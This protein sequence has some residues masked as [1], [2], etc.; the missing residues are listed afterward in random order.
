MKHGSEAS[1]IR[2]RPRNESV[3]ISRGRTALGMDR[4]GLIHS[5]SSKEGLFVYQTRVLSRYRWLMN[6]KEPNLSTQSAVEQHCWLAYYFQAPPN[7]KQTPTGDCNPLQQTVELKVSRVVGEGLHEDVEVT[8]HTQIATAITLSLEVD[9]DFAARDELQKGRKQKGKLRRHW[10]KTA[11]GEWHW[12][13]Q[14]SSQ[15]SYN[16]QGN[17]GV[18]RF[19]RGIRLQLRADS[20]ATNSGKTISF[21]IQLKPHETWKA[22]MIWQPQVDGKPLPVERN[23]NALMSSDG[24]YSRKTLSFLTQSTLVRTPAAADLSAAVQRVI[25][26]SRLD[27]AALRLFDLDKGDHN[28]K[29]AAGVPTYM[30]IFSRDM[31]AAAWQASM[32]STDMSWGALSLLAGLQAHETNDWRDA[33]PG[34]IAHEAHTDPLAVLNFNPR[35]LY[36]GTAN[37]AFLYPIVASEVWHWTGDK[38]RVRPF[39]KPALEALAWADKYS[40]DKSGFYKYKTR[41]TQGMKNQGWKDSRDAIVYPDGSQVEDPLGTCEM[42]AFA[43]VAK[44]QFSELLWWMGEGAQARTLHREA[45]ELKEKFN[46][47]FLVEDEGYLAMAIDKH[48]R[49]VRTIASDPGH[50][51]L[52]GIVNEDLVPRLVNR[53]MQP[54]LFSG[55]GIRTLSS[56]H[57]AFNPFAYHRGTVW[58]VE[59]GAFVLAFARYG[60]HAEMWRLAK[61]L[62]EAA[63]LFDYDRLPEVFGGHARDEQ[64]PFPGLYEKADSPQAW[65]AAVPFAMVQALLGI[66]PYAPLNVLFLDPW[67]PDWLPEITIEDLRVGNALITM[68]FKRQPNG[69]TGYR[70]TQLEGDLHVLRQPSPW[71]LTT[72]WGERVKDAITSLLP[73]R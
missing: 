41:S 53:M 8:N 70:V 42:Q 47:R 30:G 59:N 1:L 72:G 29:L 66:Y 35:A 4:R 17:R 48:D 13:F 73:G 62:F 25:D 31:L 68:N 51:L 69:E 40:R 56:K 37:A 60:L 12:D 20:K 58:P 50:C 22:C 61:A 63:A 5:E 2:I 57:P 27:L 64:H 9:A 21:Q 28:W 65:S 19:E 45:N 26:R 23:C 3:S 38:E 14:Y 33:Q 16:H 18:A 36:F 39:I 24:E 71:S 32:L 54:D 43:Y 67:L 10:K 44:L 11:D 52:S 49:P 7:C 55:W 46:Q 34:R 15:H 6:G